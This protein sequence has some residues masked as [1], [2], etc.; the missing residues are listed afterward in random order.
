MKKLPHRLLN[1]QSAPLAYE[2]DQESGSLSEDDQTAE[3]KEND[4]MLSPTPVSA[5]APRRPTLPKRPLSDLPVPS[6]L[7]PDP[8]HTVLLSASEQ[9]IANGP[10]TT[11]SNT[12]AECLRKGVQP[13]ERSTS[14]DGDEYCLQDLAFNGVPAPFSN[15]NEDENGVRPLKRICTEGGKENAT[16]ASRFVSLPE[17]SLLLVRGTTRIGHSAPRKASAPG[18]SI[19][20][21]AKAMSRVGVRR[22]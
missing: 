5:Q 15:E 22:L 16:G 18:L 11:S 17:R 3:S 7:D 10:A 2:T 14:E 6:G 12:I 1:T 19:A 13:A 4:P 20:G 8:A 9:N 21:R